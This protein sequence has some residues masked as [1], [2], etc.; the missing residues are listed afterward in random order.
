MRVAFC[1]FAAIVSVALFGCDRR[2]EQ[3]SFDDSK[4]PKAAPILL[5]GADGLEW[6]VILPLLADGQL[7]NIARLIERGS[8]GYLGTF[9]PTHSPI[10]WTSVATGK[11]REKHGILDFSR[12]DFFGKR[13][14]YSNSDRTAK[15]LWNILS[16]YDRRTATVGWWMTYPVDQVNGVMV[17]Q[18]NTTAQ[19]DTR[20]GQHIWKGTLLKGLPG[21]VYPPERQNEMIDILAQIEGE[22]SSL[23][24]RIFGDFQ[25]PLSL[26]GRRLWENC[27][28]AFRADETYYRITS[29]LISDQ[30]P[31]DLM[32]VYYGGPDVVGHRFWRYAHPNIYQDKPSPAEISNFGGIIDDYYRH[33]D[34]QIGKLLAAYGRDV[35]VMIVSDHGMKAVNLKKHFDP[36][37]PPANVNSGDHQDA[38]PG[39]IIA[40]GPNIRRMSPARPPREL[41]ASD[42]KEIANLYDI[43][44]TILALL[45][46]PVGRDLDGK[47]LAELIETDFQVERQPPAIATHDT[48][49]FVAN[50]PTISETRVDEGERLQQL[51][52]L[53]YLGN[54][55]DDPNDD[56]DD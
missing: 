38:P 16:D 43:T 48:A 7:P 1:T 25:S 17:A 39:V 26:L 2:T 14:L 36:D 46:I 33:V 13:V 20:F 45:R 4:L 27:R 21:Q 24:G 54:D 53:G 3:N 23:T 34:D 22:M 37:N 47:V 31:Y 56:D 50:R 40:A 41:K 51:R 11:A 19:V 42:L 44:P 18:T 9:L 35:N 32:M 49:E 8:C 30:E 12:K 28:W 29:R 10:L 55:K 6:N 5:I 15:A 52:S